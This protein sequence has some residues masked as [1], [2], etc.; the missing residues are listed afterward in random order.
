MPFVFY[1]F[2]P[3]IRSHCKYAAE[4]QEFLKKMQGQ[5]DEDE[6]SENEND[7]SEES[8]DKAKEH[9]EEREEVEQEAID[10]SYE[11]KDEQPRLEPIKS[12]SRPRPQA[13]QREKILRPFAF[14]FR[15]RCNKRE[16]PMG[17][18]E[19]RNVST[20]EQVEQIEQTMSLG[21]KL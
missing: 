8:A 18:T 15:S 3:Q 21:E 13:M 7:Q 19:G 5:A 17:T 20:V 2:G 4:A 14:R 6:A 1:K 16:F 9:E 10:Y 12:H 11:P